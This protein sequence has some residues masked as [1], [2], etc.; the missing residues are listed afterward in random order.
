MHT[1]EVGWSSLFAVHCI[2]ATLVRWCSLNEFCSVEFKNT[3]RAAELTSW[4]SESL[5]ISRKP[6]SYCS[7]FKRNDLICMFYWSCLINFCSLWLCSFVKRKKLNMC[8]RCCFAC[9]QV[10]KTAQQN[11]FSRN[12]MCLFFF[13]RR[14]HHHS[15][16]HCWRKLC[17]SKRILCMTSHHSKVK[18]LI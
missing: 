18:F 14:H 7:S 13:L 9:A 10:L 8:V 4:L 11:G 12:V 1:N 2:H 3:S 5:S 6:S 15:H 16:R 17:D